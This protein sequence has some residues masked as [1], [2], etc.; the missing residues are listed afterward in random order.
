MQTKNNNCKLKL[1]ILFLI[2]IVI[3][4]SVLRIYG[5]GY[6]SLWTDELAS[7]DITR[8]DNLKSVINETI[9]DDLPPGYYIFQYYIQKYFGDSEIVLRIPSVFGGLL[10]IIA[11][12]ILGSRLYSEKECLIAAALMSITWCP[13]Y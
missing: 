2:V 12:F 6:Q 1:T 11:I 10:C 3:F 5:L 4:G 9:K 13:I 7:W 8:K